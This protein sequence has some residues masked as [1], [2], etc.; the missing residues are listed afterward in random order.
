MEIE[1]IRRELKKL[2]DSGSYKYTSIGITARVYKDYWN[3]KTLQE[4]RETAFI[5]GGC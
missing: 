1:Q 4:A 3:C 2:K 5:L